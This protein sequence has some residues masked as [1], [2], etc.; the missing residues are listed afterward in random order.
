MTWSRV[1]SAASSRSNGSPR[2]RCCSF[3]R[4]CSSPRCRRGPSGGTRPRWRPAKAARDLQR[5]WPAGDR[6]RGRARRRSTS[7]PITGSRPS[8]RRR[9]RVDGRR[10]SRRPDPGRGARAYAGDR[11]ARRL[12]RSARGPTRRSRRCA[13]TTTGAGDAAAR[14]RARD[15]HGMITLWVLG[16]TISVMFLGGLGLDLW[17]AIAVRRE[18]S[19][20][21]DAAATA[22]ANGLDETALRGDELHLDEPRVRAAR[23][24]RALD[25]SG[26][27]ATRRRR[28][29]RGRRAGERDAARA[30]A[31]LACSASSW[32]AGSSPCRPARPPSRARPRDRHCRC[33]ERVGIRAALRRRRGLRIT[34]P[35]RSIL[36]AVAALVAPFDCRRSALHPA[37]SSV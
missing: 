35:E 8:R 15:Q 16:L 28:G 31:L 17:R 27:A 23:G 11:V 2:S 19:V 22:G 36:C 25:V 6:R 29:H 3:R 10:E 30:R 1:A 20:M 7:R 5:H 26:L 34:A 18:V 33:A 14:R 4:S 13:S 21:A 37:S 32:A 9:A 12:A 24:G